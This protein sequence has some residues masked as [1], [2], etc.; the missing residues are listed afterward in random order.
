MNRVGK[1]L[2]EFVL[3]GE[4]EYY[5]ELKLGGLY[6]YF[7]TAMSWD[8]GDNGVLTDEGAGRGLF[9]KNDYTDITEGWYCT[10]DKNA[11]F[12]WLCEGTK[13][14]EAHW[15]PEEDTMPN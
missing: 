6:Y 10:R 14:G 13:I 9:F 2:N 5:D 7:Y 4:T 1:G 3:Y 15:A 8:N 11:Y 12:N